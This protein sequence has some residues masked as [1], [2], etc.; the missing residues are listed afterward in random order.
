MGRP[1]LGQ[2]AMTNTER[3][4]RRRQRV[5]DELAEQ[6]RIQRAYFGDRPPLSEA[7]RRRLL[8]E[9]RWILDE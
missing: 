4:Q 7:E 9:Q 2:R 5:R 8:R 3:T 1:P 6:E